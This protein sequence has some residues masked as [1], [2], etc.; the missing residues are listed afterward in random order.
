MIPVEIL[1]DPRKAFFD[2]WP[3]ILRTL[4]FDL[5]LDVRY[6]GLRISFAEYAPVKLFVVEFTS[7]LR[8]GVYVVLRL[9]L[10]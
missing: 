8:L 6:S 4:A 7:G 9:K 2:V 1:F 5:Q 3:N 10:G